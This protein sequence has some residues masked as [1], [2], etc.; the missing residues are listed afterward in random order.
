MSNP[1]IRGVCEGAVHRAR[2]SAAKIEVVIAIHQGLLEE[3]KQTNISIKLLADDSEIGAVLGMLAR[4]PSKSSDLESG[5]T[6]SGQSGASRKK[7]GGRA[8]P[9]HKWP[10]LLDAQFDVSETKKKRKLWHTSDM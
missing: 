6:A 1:P 8:S 7:A 3:H 9:W 4:E 2:P 10:A 5:A